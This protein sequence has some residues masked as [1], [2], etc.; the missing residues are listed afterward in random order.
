[1][2]DAT[3]AVATQDRRKLAVQAAQEAGLDST[4]AKVEGDNAVAGMVHSR[5]VGMATRGE[6]DNAQATYD[7]AVADKVLVGKASTDTQA[8]INRQQ[9]HNVNVARQAQR[10]NDQQADRKAQEDVG[11]I[12]G[13]YITDDPATG[14]PLVNP[15]IFKALSDYG[16][17]NPYAQ[18]YVEQRTNYA[19]NQQKLQQ[20]GIAV[21]TDRGALSGL[22]D[23][24]FDGPQLTTENDIARAENEAVSGRP[25][26]A[27]KEGDWLR[28]IV[29]MRER[30]TGDA[31]K[32]PQFK[33][34]MEWAKTS[35]LGT[36]VNREYNA[37]RYAGFQYQFLQQY[38]DKVR[39][40][41]LDANDLDPG[42]PDGLLR[43]TA[44]TW[45]PGI[46]ETVRN[47][48]GAGAPPVVPAAPAAPPIPA[49]GVITPAAAA[50]AAPPT[51]PPLTL[52]PV[53]QRKVGQSYPTARGVM[54]WTGTG[55]V[56]AGT[57]KKPGAP[58]VGM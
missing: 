58:E 40:K 50:P 39:D 19:R 46:G 32:S 21:P 16:K 33:N 6:Y 1:M 52:P 38:L 18:K 34:A 13:K 17:T 3:F 9:E 25:G 55:W 8:A 23:R 54:D 30:A 4:A 43:K 29:Q 44:E 20:A 11:E 51:P 15:G 14:L 12:S 27:K 26:I 45:A 35:I 41:K 24:M 2:D 57:Y 5:V 28:S 37:G 49:P 42:N 10:F 22:T 48:G 31:L 53:K 36:G 56:P 7:K 47:N